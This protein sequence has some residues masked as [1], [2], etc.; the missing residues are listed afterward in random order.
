[1]DLYQIIIAYYYSHQEIFPM[2]L[3]KKINITPYDVSILSKLP[4]KTKTRL[5]AFFPHAHHLLK[6][7]MVLMQISPFIL[8]RCVYVSAVTCLSL[9]NGHCASQYMSIQVKDFSSPD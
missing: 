4:L 5:C 6:P 7:I 8:E 9:P 3:K 2:P 1:M